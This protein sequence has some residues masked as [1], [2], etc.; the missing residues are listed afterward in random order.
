MQAQSPE[1]ETGERNL[2]HLIQNNL[3]GDMN[4][5]LLKSSRAQ[6]S[7]EPWPAASL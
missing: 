6:S 4:V 7:F 3:V 2:K 1:R 5:Q